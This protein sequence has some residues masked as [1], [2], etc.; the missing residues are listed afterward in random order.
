MKV[1]LSFLRMLFAL[2]LGLLLVIFPNEAGNFFVIA[3]GTIFLIPSLLSIA[4][5]LSSKQGGFH[6][7]FFSVG[8]LLFGLWLII[9]PEFFVTLLTYVLGFVLLMGGVQQ[10][11]SLQVARQWVK[12]SPYYYIV[13]V[14]I[15]LAGL[16]ALFNPGGVQRTA[17]LVIGCASLF[18]A[19]QELVSWFSLMRLRPKP[20]VDEA[21]QDTQSSKESRTPSNPEDSNDDDDIEDAEIIEISSDR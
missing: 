21:S 15:L 2:I 4:S 9:T 5:A 10:L 7:P 18:Y 8:S 20:R 17:F 6:F 13:P 3:I 11:S 19:L 16:L 1:N 12:V 14:L